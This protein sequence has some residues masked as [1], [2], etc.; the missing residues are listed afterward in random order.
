MDSASSSSDGG[1]SG[2]WRGSRRQWGT[3]GAPIWP[4]DGGGSGGGSRSKRW[5]WGMTGAVSK[6]AGEGVAAMVASGILDS[7]AGRAG[8][9][10]ID[11]RHCYPTA[12]ES[13]VLLLEHSGL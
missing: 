2:Q 13:A 6:C 8:L 10:C 1:C 9:R 3:G 7:V 12:C 5:A 4:G 11:G